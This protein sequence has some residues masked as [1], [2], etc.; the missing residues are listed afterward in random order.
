MKPDSNELPPL[1][2]ILVA[3]LYLATNFAKSGC[4]RLSHLIMHQLE[5]VLSHS[6]ETLSPPVRETCQRLHDVW[7]QI[8]AECTHALGDTEESEVTR[9]VH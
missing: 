1:E 6:A 5:F 7:E 9:R 3:A 8:H 4:P 2:N